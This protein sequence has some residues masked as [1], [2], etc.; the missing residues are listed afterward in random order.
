M[1]F[2]QT[3]TIKKQ[4]ASIQAKPY[5]YHFGSAEGNQRKEIDQ[6]ATQELMRF[7]EIV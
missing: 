3:R 4:I 5:V 2:V 1:L 6:K 7:K